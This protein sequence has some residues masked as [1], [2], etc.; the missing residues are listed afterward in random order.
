METLTWQEKDIKG[1]FKF[2]LR[3]FLA[4]QKS[5]K[6]KRNFSKAKSYFIGYA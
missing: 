1:T 6:K 5:T 3:V 4:Y 2:N